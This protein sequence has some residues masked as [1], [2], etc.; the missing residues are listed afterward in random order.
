MIFNV[1]NLVHHLSLSGVRM[2]VAI[3]LYGSEDL[4]HLL[5]QFSVTLLTRTHDHIW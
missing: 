5:Y 3:Y 4:A 1:T 2:N